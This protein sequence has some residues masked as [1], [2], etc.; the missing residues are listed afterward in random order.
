[1]QLFSAFPMEGISPH[2]ENS[3]NNIVATTNSGNTKFS[4]LSYIKAI[5][6]KKLREEQEKM[7]ISKSKM[8]QMRDHEHKESIQITL[9][10]RKNDLNQVIKDYNLSKKIFDQEEVREKQSA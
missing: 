2:R 4:L 3:R 1:M 5:Q 9:E 7:G 10:E 6:E 8:A